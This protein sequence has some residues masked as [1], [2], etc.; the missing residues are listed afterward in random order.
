MNRTAFVLIGYLFFTACAQV[1]EPQGGPKDTEPPRLVQAVPANGSTHFSG[2]RIVL[3]F[4]ER[5]KLDRVRDKL[6]VSPPLAAQPDVQVF[7]GM[8]V[9]VGLMAP[10]EDSTTYTFNLGEAV[11]D[12]SEGNPAA[13]LTYVVSTGAYVDSLTM[14][15]QVIEARSGLP[16]ADVPVILQVARDT[17]DMRTT[18]P[19]YFT[20][21]K[22]DGSFLFTHLRS[23]AMRL[24]ALR[25]RNG[26]FR[27]DLP[28]EDI[29]FMDASVYPG[30]TLP[31]TLLLFQA[32]PEKQL[33]I[34][35]KVLPERGWQLLFARPAGEVGLHSLDRRGDKLSWWPEWNGNRDTLVLWPSDTAWLAGQRFEVS[36]DGVSLDTLTYHVG[37]PMPFHF[38]VTAERQANG[39]WQLETSRPVK[40]VDTE[41]ATLKV[42]TAVI[43]WTVAPD[44]IHGRTIGLNLVPVPGRSFVLLLYPKAMT[45]AMG[46]T[47]DTTKL[48]LGAVDPR[49]LGKLK[50]SLSADSG[51]AL[52][53]PF[54]LQL[55]AAQGGLVR[56]V[57]FDSLPAEVVWEQLVPGS[58]GLKWIGDRNGDGRWST[59]TYL[60]PLQPERVFLD[61]EPVQ[62]RAGWSVKRNW[63]LPILP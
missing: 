12:L 3:R 19:T 56:E 35:T 23:G 18:A 59:G 51:M 16:A 9:V 39:L 33:I 52:Q 34:G 43:A 38:T 10:L 60:P 32:V 26:N 49:S 54:V 41:L 50:V 62:I 20:R 14:R 29:A 22:A 30:D 4:D 7:K 31:H 63:L 15:G 21:T 6:L 28:S 1:R 36:E 13:G 45:A 42:D 57:R 46:G 61:P 53:G 27:Y 47:N 24:Y 25:D 37:S 5:V 58:Y 8:E 11:L 40:T 17:G 2:G 55:I 48:I 44:S